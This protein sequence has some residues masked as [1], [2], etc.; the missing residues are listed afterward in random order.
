MPLASILAS[1]RPAAVCGISPAALSRLAAAGRPQAPPAPETATAAARGGR[2]GRD[3][4]G[5]PAKVYFRTARIRLPRPPPLFPITSFGP[6]Q[7]SQ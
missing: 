6:S 2:G 1:S 4:D 3:A 5:W 7:R